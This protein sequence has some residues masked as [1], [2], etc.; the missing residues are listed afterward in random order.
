MTRGRK[1]IDIAGRRFGR[2][3]ASEPAP[4][5]GFFSGKRKAWWCLCDCGARVS[6]TASNLHSGQVRSCGCMRGR[7]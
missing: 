4:V 1:P 2:L 6:V 5:R 7:R 3:I